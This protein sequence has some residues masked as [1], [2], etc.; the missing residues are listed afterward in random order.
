MKGYENGTKGML[1]TFIST[2]LSLFSLDLLLCLVLFFR[3]YLA[4]EK[5]CLL[6]QPKNSLLAGHTYVPV[7]VPAT[8]VVGASVAV[9]VPV[10]VPVP[11]AVP[12][13][14]PVAVT[15]CTSTKV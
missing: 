13:P 14:V 15:D 3:R 2:I 11:V 10:P 9:P 1:L 8:V 7:P 12:P 6:F 4:V 5:I